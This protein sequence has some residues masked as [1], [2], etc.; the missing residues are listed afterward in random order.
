MKTGKK[1]LLFLGV[2]AVV[3]AAAIFLLI[4]NLDAIV[5]KSIEKYGSRATG[6]AVNVS[7]VRIGIREGEGSI[8]GLIIGN[9]KGFS[10]PKAFGLEDI[11]VAIDAA[12]VRDD[13]VIIEKVQVSGPEVVYEINATG[14]SNIDTIKSNLGAGEKGR[15]PAQKETGG[16]EKK[17]VIRDFIVEDGKVEIRVAA[18]GDKPISA[19]LPRIHLKNL[20]GKGGGTPSEIAEQVLGPLVSSAVD[21]ASKAGIQQYLGKSAEEVQ[22]MLE[23][24]KGKIEGV[25]KDAVKDAEGTL[26][27]LLGK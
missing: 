23:A 17:I 27:K 10:S 3:I 25:G 15:E 4:S 26:K 5:K 7:A 20:G 11:S 14:K 8:S 12:S 6:T 19:A 1:V 13:T 16:K 18:L 22:R 2:V 21:A 9:P 24:G